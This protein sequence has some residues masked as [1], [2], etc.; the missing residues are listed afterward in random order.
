MFIGKVVGK[1]W[2]TRKD[3]KLEGQKFLI[4][5]LLKDKNKEDDGIFV[6]A[7][8]VGAGQGDTVLIVR[9]GSARI[10]LGN[11]EVPIDA[12]I[13]AIIDSIEVEDE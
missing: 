3:E 2:A 9:G 4:I 10:A 5:K 13:V 12:A 8:S 6:A 1:L 11:K 7:D